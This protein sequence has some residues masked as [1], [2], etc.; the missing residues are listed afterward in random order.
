MK[1][2]YI[3]TG[4]YR[5]GTSMMMQALKAG[6]LEAVW[7]K[8]HEGE[9]DKWKTKEYDPNPHGYYELSVDIYNDREFPKQYEGKLVKI[10]SGHVPK[11]AVGNYK[12]VFMLRDPKEI[13]ISLI[14]MMRQVPAIDIKRYDE[15]MERAINAIKNRRDC[16][17]TV[18]HYKDV[19][20]EPFPYFN[21]LVHRGWPID[22]WAA[23]AKVDPKLYRNRF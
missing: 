9:L 7:D 17:L 21:R 20:K 8:E 22:P 11:I 19:V 23:A 4:W 12:I 18:F 5:S 1:T 3:V 16:E 14:K 6:G 13:E 10:L 15:E 2:T